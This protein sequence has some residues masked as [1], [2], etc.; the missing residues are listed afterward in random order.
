MIY[1]KTFF[2]WLTYNPENAP[3]WPVV[4]YLLFCIVFLS[5]LIFLFVYCVYRKFSWRNLIISIACGVYL[6][7]AILW[8]FCFPGGIVWKRDLLL[9]SPGIVV[10]FA[11]LFRRHRG[12]VK[13][14]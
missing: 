1:L 7:L 2:N 13:V 11:G 3:I 9:F 4:G 14:E 5:A 6:T 12:R 10:I 8:S